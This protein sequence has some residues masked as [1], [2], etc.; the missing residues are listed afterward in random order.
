MKKITSNAE[1]IRE[2]WLL[3]GRFTKGI[4]VFTAVLIILF[5]TWLVFI[6][7]KS[8]TDQKI[9]NAIAPHITLAVHNSCFSSHTLEIISSWSRPI[10]YCLFIFF[11]RAGTGWPSGLQ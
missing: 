10:S 3:R 1:K 7:T 8:T 9:F 6:Y 4:F 5:M 11:T 2:T